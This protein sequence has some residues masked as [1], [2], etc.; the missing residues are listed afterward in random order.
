MAYRVYA[1]LHRPMYTASV[2]DFGWKLCLWNLCDYIRIIK[3]NE[4]YRCDSSSTPRCSCFDFE[5][6]ACD[7]RSAFQFPFESN[8]SIYFVDVRFRFFHFENTAHASLAENPRYGLTNGRSRT[9]RKTN[10]NVDGYR[11]LKL[12]FWIP[13]FGLQPTADHYNSIINKIVAK[14]L[15]AHFPQ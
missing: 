11:T 9:R 2:S 10:K 13:R 6:A 5:V 8:I 12:K 7:W 15:K 14:H 3:L 4:I 1:A